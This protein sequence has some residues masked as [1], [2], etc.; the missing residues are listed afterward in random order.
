[1]RLPD[2]DG[3]LGYCL[4]VHPTQTLDD[5]C[6]ALLGPVREVKQRI[7]PDAPFGV[8][9]RLSAQAVA[10]P[11][12]AAGEI[13]AIFAAEGYAA[14]TMNGF[15]YG[16]FHGAPIKTAVYE[17]DW[18]TRERRLYTRNLAILMAALIDEAETA[19][20]STAPGG[21]GPLLRGREAQVVEGILR[22]VADLIA[23]AH[24]TRRRVALALEPEPWC[25]LDSISDAIAFFR[26]RLYTEAAAVRLSQLTGLQLAE[27]R[28]AL[29][30]HV[31]LCL[32][33][34][35]MAVS[36]EEPEETL[37]ALAEAHIPIHKIQLSAALRVESLT[38]QAFERFGAFNDET[39]LHQVV[40][41]L[42]SGELQR[43]LDLPEALVHSEALRNGE[44]R[45]HFHVPIFAELKAPLRSTRDV[46]DRILALHRCSP[47]C[48]HFE[49]ETYTWDVL[50]PD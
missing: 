34:C 39:Y 13:A 11:A 14:F 24:E 46:L 9:L 1:M 42:P 35:H 41:R 23:I 3:W 28:A 45:V 40:A 19:T 38:P 4:N 26:D 5:V 33:V 25:L 15:A 2:C 8:G 18:T 32:D 44:L 49:V 48:R 36:F 27:A 6:A 7:C 12:R 47:I 43:F 10:D 50:P 30:E 21:F 29:R 22:S 16:R 37:A 17:P 31:G 20:I